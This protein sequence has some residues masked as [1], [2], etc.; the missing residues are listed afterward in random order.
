MVGMLMDCS[1]SGRQTSLKIMALSKRPVIFSHSSVGRLRIIAVTSTMSRSPP[2]PRPA[3]SSALPASVCFLAT[4]TSRT[5]TIIRHMDYLAERVGAAH[6]GL[7]TDFE[8]KAPPVTATCRGQSAGSMVAQGFRLWRRW[9][10]K[11]APPGR[12]R[13]RR[14]PAA[15][16]LHGCRCRRRRRR[17]LSARRQAAWPK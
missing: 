2:A 11:T 1:H 9:Q 14:W 3:A 17:K 7:G 15:P 12:F 13:D 10:D 6:I 16:R 5:E 8:F 4:M